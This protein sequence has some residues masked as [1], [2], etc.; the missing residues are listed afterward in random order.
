[1]LE[2][3]AALSGAIAG[4]VRYCPP[5]SEEEPAVSRFLLRSVV[6]TGVLYGVDAKVINDTTLLATR[7]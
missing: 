3:A 1:M 2:G 5:E 6:V 7:S 4:A